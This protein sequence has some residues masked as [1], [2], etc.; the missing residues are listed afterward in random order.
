MLTSFTMFEDAELGALLPWAGLLLG[1]FFGALA[2]RSRF[3]LRSAVVETGRGLSPMAGVYAAA[4]LV[5]VIGAF[6]LSQAGVVA[7]E[8]TR[9]FG[10]CASRLTVLG[11]QGNLRALFVMLVFAI[12][13]YATLR[14]VLAGWRTGFT[15][16][17]ALDVS[18]QGYLPELLGVAPVLLVGFIALALAALVWRSGAR[19]S[20]IA[21]GAGVGAVV[22]GG[23]FATGALLYDEFAPRAAESLAFT[24]GA[25]DGLFYAMASTALEPGF[26][27]GMIGGVILGAFVA[28]LLSREL[29]LESF[30]TPGQTVRYIAG[31]VLMG[32]G[33]VLAGGCTVGAGLTG[34]STLTVG[35]VIALAAIIVGAKAAQ[36][37]LESRGEAVTTMVPAE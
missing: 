31:G 27:A 34:V 28:A 3:C 33:G 35:P 15:E 30:E 1:L 25:S 29:R 37:A 24:A 5:A 13:A 10:D 22:I 9:F 19:V 7:F 2:Q 32:V 18:A 26:A 8:E 17:T 12:T 20:Q 4:L 21:M 6:A 14:G 16:A 11:A 23:W 36:L